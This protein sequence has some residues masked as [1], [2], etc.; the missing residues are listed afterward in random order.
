MSLSKLREMVKDRE[1]WSAAVA[2]SD[3]TEWLNNNTSAY[4]R[5]LIFLAEILIPACD[6][7]SLAFQM[8]YSAHKLNQQVDHM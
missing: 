3:T 4:L 5:L 2:E 8:T 7:S 1:A 6:S